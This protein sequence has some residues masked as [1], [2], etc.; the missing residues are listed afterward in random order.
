M[1]WP[2]WAAA[3]L[4]VLSSELLASDGSPWRPT[5]L[6]KLRLA[7]NK[8]IIETL[9]L[10]NVILAAHYCQ[11]RIWCKTFCSDTDDP[12]LCYL[13]S[14]LT[15][16]YNEDSYGEPL[17]SCY[18]SEEVNM[19]T[20]QSGITVYAATPRS[21]GDTFRSVENLI[22]GVYE[23]P[24]ADDCFKSMTTD[25]PFFV[26]DL[27]S[28][29]KVERVTLMAQ[30]NEYAYLYFKSIEVRLG[31]VPESGNFSTYSL[32]GSYKGTPTA[33][34]IYS[35]PTARNFGRYISVQFMEKKFKLQVC[36]VQI[37]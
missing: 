37:F 34:F 27:G 7:S 22:D 10:P 8:S 28:V 30:A 25:Y 24:S 26:L 29:M 32:L 35:T 6:S 11:E 18:T 20:A 21:I 3:L 12:S 23:R 33:D 16:P 9:Y 19:L 13:L 36:H 4:S 2:A 5:R 31:L 14:T 15:A 1:N 17:M